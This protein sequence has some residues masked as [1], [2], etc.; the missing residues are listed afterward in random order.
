M[1]FQDSD[2][3][4]F[5]IN[6]HAKEAR[7]KKEKRKGS[8]SMF[9]VF[10]KTEGQTYKT[11]SSGATKD[12]FRGPFSHPKMHRL[13]TDSAFLH[14]KRACFSRVFDPLFEAGLKAIRLKT[15]K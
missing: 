6:D 2:D 10:V 5:K 9:I 12:Q 13:Q 8:K 1:I 15:E 11:V 4:G 14:R 3:F 7:K